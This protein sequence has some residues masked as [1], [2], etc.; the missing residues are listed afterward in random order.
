MRKTMIRTLIFSIILAVAALSSSA[1]SK[2]I[3]SG[4]V[5]DRATNIYLPKAQCKVY[6]ANGIPLDS[7]KASGY[8]DAGEGYI[9]TSSFNLRVPKQEG[10][11][12]LEFIYPD[13]DTTRLDYELKGIGKRETLRKI[14]TIYLN[15]HQEHTL[16]ELTVTATKVMFYHKGDTIVYNA[17]A[18][19]LSEGSML[20]ALVGALPGVEIKDGGRIFV[21]G[22]YVESLLLDGKE[23]FK[24]NNQIMLNNLGAYTVKDI[25]VYEKM[26]D[27]NKFVGNDLADGKQLV[28]DVK[29]KQ[30]FKAGSIINIEAGGGTSERYLGRLFAMHF[31]GDNRFTLLGN[32]NNLNKTSRAS[33]NSHFFISTSPTMGEMTVYDGGFDYNAAFG[34]GQFEGDLFVTGTKSTLNSTTSATNYLQDAVNYSYSRSHSVA[35]DIKVSTQHKY[36][37]QTAHHI[38]QMQGSYQ[39]MRSDAEMGAASMLT[40]QETATER[41]SALLDRISQGDMTVEMRD[42]LINQSLTLMSGKT[43]KS[44]YS[45]SA[46]G[47]VKFDRIPDWISWNVTGGYDNWHSGSTTERLINYADPQIPGPGEMQRQKNRPNS[48]FKIN[49]FAGYNY[50]ASAKMLLT[51]GY[52]FQAIHKEQTSDLYT[53]SIMADATGRFDLIALRQMQ[54]VF[55]PS[56]SYRSKGNDFDHRIVPSLTYAP[57]NFVSF[58][59]I[60]PLHFYYDRLDYRRGDIHANPS[61]K[62]AG[63]SGTQLSLQWITQYDYDKSTMNTFNFK[64]DI[65]TQRPDLVKTIDIVDDI[66]P[67]NVYLGN[68]GLKN[69]WKHSFAAS[70]NIGIRPDQTIQINT[71]FSVTD[72]ALV[73]GY[74]LDPTSGQRLFKTYNVGGNYDFKVY[75]DYWKKLSSKFKYRGIL[76]EEGYGYSGMYGEGAQ[77]VARQKSHAY[78]TRLQQGIKFSPSAHEFGLTLHGLWRREITPNR[79]T[80][81]MGEISADI[82]AFIS[83]PYG[84]ELE[85]NFFATKR[86][87]YTNKSLNKFYPL[88]NASLTYSLGKGRW[89]LGLH[90]YDI[91]RKMD[92]VEAT[93]NANGRVETYYNYIPRYVMATVQFR[94]N[95]TPAKTAPEIIY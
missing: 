76:V 8:K 1:Q 20:D 60:V 64:Y 57:S 51:L 19:K 46:A 3:L 34:G 43:Y 91:L 47:N 41:W 88:W 56:N 73:S 87:G 90:A 12:T 6:D 54:E 24:G 62:S 92:N 14:G 10:T 11:Y 9:L 38:L 5:R 32:V 48:S 78:H 95:H 16:N 33:K 18:F 23:F 49:V 22:R 25:R 75:L 42:S 85:S 7:V 61:R 39:F 94:F 74:W 70:Y 29:L 83:L 15:R 86:M 17:D 58:R 67:L 35:K 77:P 31:V 27:M 26:T 4:E 81:N 40:S 52:G 59:A 80:Y 84:L 37:R 82:E 2:I 71:E 45:L 89:L 36:T 69:S 63:L 79:G 28:M 53:A 66:D 30:E 72:N 21:N 44:Q 93:M 13:F 68:P 55:Q 50:R 65:T